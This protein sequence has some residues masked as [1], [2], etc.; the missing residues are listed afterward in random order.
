MNVGKPVTLSERCACTASLPSTLSHN[1]DLLIESP[2]IHLNRPTL[3]ARL[4]KR[5]SCSISTT[6]ICL[7]TAIKGQAL[8]NFLVA[9]PIPNSL[10]FTT[11]LPN[12]EVMLITSQKG[13][14]IFF[15]GASKSPTGYGKRMCRIIMPEIEILFISPDDALIQYSFSLTKGAQIIQQNMKLSLPGSS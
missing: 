12:E 3:N 2:Q 6:L 8:A 14:E 13:W 11:D 9:H 5:R 4:A 1:L 10:S 7:S 15:D